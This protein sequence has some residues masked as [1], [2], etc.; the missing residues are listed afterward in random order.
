MTVSGFV[1]EYHRPTGVHR[2]H[3]FAGV[4][5]HQDAMRCRLELEAERADS[6]WEIVSLNSASLDTLKSTHSRY[7]GVEGELQSA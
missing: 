7:F 4:N 6:D 5:G 1:I 3:E 2:V